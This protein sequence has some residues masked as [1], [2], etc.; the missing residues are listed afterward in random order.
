MLPKR[1]KRPE[2]LVTPHKAIRAGF[3]SQA[4]T[5]GTI[6]KPHIARSVVFSKALSKLKNAN[7]LFEDLPGFRAELIAATGFSL[8]GAS[9]LSNDELDVVVK[10]ALKAS[11]ATKDFRTELVARYLLTKGDSL[12]GTMRNIIGSSA[13]VKLVESLLKELKRRRIKPTI[14][15]SKKGKVQNI[16]WNGRWLR[17]DCKSKIIGKN[18]DAI[19]L[20]ISGR[21]AMDDVLNN[22]TRYIAAGELKGG[23]DP[24]GADEHWKTAGSALERI[25][26]SFKKEKHKPELFFVGAAIESSMAEEIFQQLKTGRLSH[27][28]NL[29]DQDQLGDLATWLVGL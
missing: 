3:L 29:T 23:I 7:N 22:P 18:I 5:K 16:R 2:D 26:T 12:G 15:K 25:R 14:E 21:G 4:V 13:G 9:H 28:A 11:S 19:L 10:Q 24:A 1:I 27:A 17:F 8:K 20:D 6:A